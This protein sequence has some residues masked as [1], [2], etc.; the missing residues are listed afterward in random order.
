MLSIE[1]SYRELLSRLRD[2]ALLGSCASVLGWDEQ[3]YLPSAGSEYRAEQLALLAGF[4]HERAT[5][6]RIGE[7]LD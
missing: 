5:S 4:T 6:P 3:T 1:A 7:L 2:A